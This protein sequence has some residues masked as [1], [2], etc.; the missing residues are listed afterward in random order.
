MRNPISDRKFIFLVVF[1]PLLVITIV[2]GM[3]AQ[4][5]STSTQEV[6]K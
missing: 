1:L 5:S 3:N 4:S 2:D 6:A